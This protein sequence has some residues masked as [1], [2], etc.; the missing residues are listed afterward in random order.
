MILDLEMYGEICP[1]HTCQSLIFY[2]MCAWGLM[3][4]VGDGIVKLIM[5]SQLYV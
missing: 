3:F 5:E 1:S 2:V 4:L